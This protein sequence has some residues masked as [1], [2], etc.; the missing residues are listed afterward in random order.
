MP[1]PYEFV[2][3]LATGQPLD[4]PDPARNTIGVAEDAYADIHITVRAGPGGAQVAVHPMRLLAYWGG[5]V[6]VAPLAGKVITGP[7]SGCY[8]M[9]FRRGGNRFIAHVGTTENVAEST[10]AKDAFRALAAQ[11]GVDQVQGYKPTDSLP[12]ENIPLPPGQDTWWPP[13]L[14]NVYTVFDANGPSWCLGFATQSNAQT[15]GMGRGYLC[16]EVMPAPVLR[17]WAVIQ[18]DPQWQ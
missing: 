2:G 7:M 14:P 16:T 11:P 5:R 6:T 18:N 3:R 17:D 1:F 13:V 4:L 15:G 9:T 8:I 12:P 10:G